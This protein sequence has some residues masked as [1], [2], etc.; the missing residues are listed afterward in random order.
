MSLRGEIKAKH[1]ELVF[2][3]RTVSFCDLA[4][5]S[6]VFVESNAWGMTKGN[7]ELYESVKAIASKY[8]T[9]VSW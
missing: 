9:I 6:K 5:D 3:T 2:K 4:R 7:Q 8:N 1:P